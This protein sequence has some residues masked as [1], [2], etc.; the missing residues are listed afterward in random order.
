M[1]TCLN[2]LMCFLVLLSFTPEAHAVPALPVDYSEFPHLDHTEY[3]A[4]QS[5]AV[6]AYTLWGKDFFAVG[7]ENSDLHIYE[8]V[9][10]AV[11]PRGIG[12]SVGADRDIAIKD[13]YAFVAT[14]AGLTAISVAV[15]ETP[16]TTDFLN[17][18]G[19]P[20][21]VDV[22]AT[23]AFVASGSGGLVIVDITDPQNMS[24]VGNYGAD[25]RSVC[26]D[27]DR[28]GIINQTRF[29]ILDVSVPGAPGLLGSIDMG[30]NYWGKVNAVL[31]GDLAY[32]SYWAQ[33][34]QLDITD[35]GAI[36]VT[37]ELPLRSNSLGHQ[38]EITGS[39]L[40]YTGPGCLAFVDFATGAITRKSE[41]AGMVWDA[42]VIAG[43]IMAVGDDRVEIFEDGFH[44][45]PPAGDVPNS[46]LMEPR[47]IILDDLL[48]GLSRS[49]PS[50]LVAAEL[51]AG[52]GLLWDLDLETD[53]TPIR[54]MAHQGSTVA[55]LTAGGDLSIVTVSRNSATLHGT[56]DMPDGFSTPF[57]RDRTVAFLNDRTLVVLDENHPY[58]DFRNIRVVDI[59]NLEQPVQ[60]GRYDLIVGD[61]GLPE[62]VMA[63]GHLVVVTSRG[64]Y[65]VFDAL[66]RLS[67]QSLGT[68]SINIT[69]NTRAQFHARDSWLYLLIDS[70]V[71][72]IGEVGPERLE[73][74]DLS[75]PV[76]P[77]LVN[78]LNLAS[79]GNLVFAG[80]WAF[81]GTSGLILDFSDP[82]QPVP[83]GNFSQPISPNV[84]WVIVQASTE[85]IV[86][87]HVLYGSD[88]GSYANYSA[89]PG[90][91]GDISSVDEDLPLSG[92]GLT[93]Q[94]VPN[95][96]NPRVTFR[97]DL[98]APSDTRLE[99]Y[100]LRG[101][102]VADLGERFRQ[103]G[104]QSVTWD[105][106]DRQGR[107]LPSGVYL[108]RVSTA[109]GAASRKIVLAR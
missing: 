22:S 81:Q 62:H 25:V 48:H 14:T 74:W 56:L 105:G 49:A 41:Q 3:L 46:V 1:R 65:E 66:D 36:L 4:G 96:F 17:L 9:D 39:E 101:R 100:D 89:A 2:I 109:K 24:I 52:G 32:V 88:L 15:P 76:T 35:P 59:S 90:A 94:A 67:L 40:L 73:T 97:F 72:P 5:L 6:E 69:G 75:N 61:T 68:H 104:P 26:L 79:P 53:G 33:V 82:A 86:V 58:S 103:A 13:W 20:V 30:S 50:T 28:L 93:L 34:K 23:H 71:S 64:G 19:E 47:G 85:Y 108:A 31:Q 43:K 78:Q 83:A 54:G 98:P 55:T 107:N 84:K 106:V 12:H 57:N 8:I 60:L 16:L 77:V 70:P 45:H 92:R 7:N 87:D 51:G 42:A 99:I 38:M 80:D 63:T 91:T 95:P 29:E 44:A 21:R 18:T 10:G 27:G 11:V 102:L 37:E